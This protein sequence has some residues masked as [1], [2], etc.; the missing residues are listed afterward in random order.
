MRVLVAGAGF[1]GGALASILAERG[2]DVIAVRRSP[3]ELRSV[4]TI[5]ADLSGPALAQALTDPIDALVYAAAADAT[6]ESAYS[7]VYVDALARTIDLARDRGAT[8]LIF[9]SSTGVYGQSGGDWVDEASPTEPARFTGRIM[10]RAEE[11]VRQ[12]GGTSLRLGGVYGPGRTRLIDTVRRGE[13]RLSP[14]PAAATH[15]TNRI[16]RDDAAGALAHLL[17]LERLDPIYLGVDE[18]PADMNDVLRFIADRLGVPTP[19]LGEPSARSAATSKR[20]RGDKLRQ[21][22]YRFQYPTYREGYA[23]MLASA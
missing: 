3:S 9:T 16:H 11:L 2:D 10:L 6:T 20:C 19:L 14:T 4:R 22:G 15:F 8:R 17:R 21:A 1:V 13:A 12:A 18:E 7:R 23:A 5:A